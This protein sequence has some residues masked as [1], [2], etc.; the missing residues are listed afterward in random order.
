MYLFNSNSADRYTAAKA[1][2]FSQLT[3]HT[4]DILVDRIKDESEYIYVRLEVASTLA[5][6][7]LKEGFTYIEKILQNDYLAY[8]LEAIIIL[9]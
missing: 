9:G 2:S 6:L 5:R 4:K 7:G 1:L 3:E 8:K